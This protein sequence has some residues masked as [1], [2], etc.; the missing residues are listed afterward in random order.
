M[1]LWNGNVYVDPQKKKI[2]G[3]TWNLLSIGPIGMISQAKTIVVKG[4]LGLTKKFSEYR[5]KS[6]VNSSTHA[7]I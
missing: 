2:V 6:W 4:G 3:L 5:P 1:G 7:C